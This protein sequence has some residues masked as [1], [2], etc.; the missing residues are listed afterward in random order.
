M[1]KK[2]TVLNLTRIGAESDELE[3]FSAR[4]PKGMPIT[5][6]NLGILENDGFRLSWVMARCIPFGPDWDNHNQQIASIMGKYCA[7]EITSGERI[8]QTL[9][10][11]ARALREHWKPNLPKDVW[12]NYG[13]TGE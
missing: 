8:H 10:E 5:G 4:F 3:R 9:E 11:Y 13:Y 2:L 7:G 6:E 12:A 1:R